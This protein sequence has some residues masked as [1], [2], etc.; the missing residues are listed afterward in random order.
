MNIF[1]ETLFSFANPYP[2][3]TNPLQPYIHQTLLDPTQEFLFA[4]DLTADI[5]HVFSITSSN[6]LQ[7]PSTQPDII[8]PTGHGPRHGVFY[9][10]G[11]GSNATYVYFVMETANMVHG[12][13]V[14]YNS[15]TTLNFT[16]I[17]DFQLPV[18]QNATAAEIKL[19]V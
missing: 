7:K 6:V 10:P 16:M 5:I 8:V 17:Q 14:T 13:E 1:Q 18:P 12:Y 3:A 15:D 11:N 9:Q 2:N 19:T 4:A